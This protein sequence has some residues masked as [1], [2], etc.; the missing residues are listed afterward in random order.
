MIKVLS[1][2]GTRPEAIKMA[3]VLLEL[4][5]H[6]EHITSCICVTAQHRQML[7][8]VLSIFRLIPDYDL[9]VM[10][11]AQSP[12]AV[13]ATVLSK[14]EPILM[15]ERPDWV[16]VQGDTT[17]LVAGALAAFYAKVKIGH[18][19]AGMRTYDKTQPFPEEGHRRIAAAIADM[20]FAPTQEAFN[21]LL[22]EHIPAENILL[23]GNTAIDALH[24]VTSL[25]YSAIAGPLTGIAWEKRI[26]LVTTHRRENQGQPLESICEALREIALR[27]QQSVHIVYPVHM[28][29]HIRKPVQHKLGDTRGITLTSPLDYLSLTHLLKRSYLVLTDSGG[30]QAEAPS[31]G[32]PL[33]VLRNTTEYKEAV[34]AGTSKLVGF[35]RQ[36]IVEEVTRLLEDRDAYKK[37]AR[38]ITSYGDGQAAKRIVAALMEPDGT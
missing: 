5:R 16:L 23:A 38:V 22:Q 11:E 13:A 7:D 37:M 10:Q 1:I 4:K 26:I 35:N 25:P 28:N 30:L 29:P 20:H 36:C 6:P 14:L 8:Q 18:V 21:N 17:T 9:N 12:T 34:A 31:L 27:Y 2:L 19:E 33:L 32:K 3:P 24:A 15:A